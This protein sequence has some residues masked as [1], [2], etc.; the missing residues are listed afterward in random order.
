MFNKKIFV[1]WHRVH[2]RNLDR[3]YISLSRARK[4]GKKRNI[5]AGTSPAWANSSARWIVRGYR[6][7]VDQLEASATGAGKQLVRTERKEQFLSFFFNEISTLTR[8]FLV[9][10][11]SLNNNND[12]CTNVARSMYSQDVPPNEISNASISLVLSRHEPH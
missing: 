12:R 8:I 5:K 6:G 11:P 2:R 4:R 10:L 3:I 9:V 7:S 1:R